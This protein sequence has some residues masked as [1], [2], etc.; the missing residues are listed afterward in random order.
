MKDPTCRVCGKVLW[1]GARTICRKCVGIQS[2]QQQKARYLLEKAQGDKPY[3]SKTVKMVTVVWCPC[4][5]DV[6]VYEKG[7]KF[8]YDQFRVSLEGKV[9]PKGMIVEVKLAILNLRE[10]TKRTYVMPREGGQRE[11]SARMDRELRT[12]EARARRSK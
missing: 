3:Q 11:L 7:S 5:N 1:G 6:P 12:W 2:S 9:W 4:E 8:P 10:E